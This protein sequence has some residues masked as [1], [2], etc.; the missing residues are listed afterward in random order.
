MLF[1][2][3]YNKGDSIFPNFPS[4]SWDK[5]QLYTWK[6]LEVKDCKVLNLFLYSWVDDPLKMI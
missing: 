5:E 6:H 4:L 2:Y 3:L 1:L